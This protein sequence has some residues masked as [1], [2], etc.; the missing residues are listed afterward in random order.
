MKRKLFAALLLLNLFA[1]FPYPVSAADTSS[2]IEE[3]VTPRYQNIA[4]TRANL[5]ID[6]SIGTAT[7]QY[8]L[9]GSSFA[10]CTVTLTIESS[11]DKKNWDEVASWTESFTTI[12][13]SMTKKRFLTRNRYYRSVATFDIY[14]KDGNLIESAD[15][16]SS[17]IYY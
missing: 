11:P 15:A 9:K 5:L 2:T 1:S 10:S 14:D 7:C 17:T 12:N 4:L 6:G 13:Q 3:S 16:T 8:Q